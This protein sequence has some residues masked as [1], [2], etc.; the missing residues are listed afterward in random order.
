MN[1]SVYLHSDVEGRLSGSRGLYGPADL[2]WRQTPH[3]EPLESPAS[4]GLEY[5]QRS[6]VSSQLGEGGAQQVQEV[7]LRKTAGTDH[8]LHR[9]LHAVNCIRNPAS[10]TSDIRLKSHKSAYVV[11]R[12]HL[13]RARPTGNPPA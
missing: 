9:G 2:R 6:V 1:N 8:P 12:Y 4:V 7:G 10:D 13:L 11:H 5:L 3:S